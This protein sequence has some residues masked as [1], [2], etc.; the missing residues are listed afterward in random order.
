MTAE[1]RVLTIDA[2]RMTFGI[3]AVGVFQQE[4]AWKPSNRIFAA[5]PPLRRLSLSFWKARLKRLIALGTGLVIAL[6]FLAH[7]MRQPQQLFEEAERQVVIN[8]PETERLLRE[9]IVAAD[10]DFPK[11]QFLYCR[12]L[13]AQRRWDEALGAFG[14]ISDAS[15]IEPSELVEFAGQARAGG[16]DLLTLLALRAAKQPGPGLSDVLR[17]LIAIEIQAG[18]LEVALGNC[19]ELLDLEPEDGVAWRILGTILLEQKEPA[20]AANA[21]EKALLRLKVPDQLTLVRQHL[22]EALLDAGMT[23]NAREQLKVLRESHVLSDEMKL[24]EAYLD[25]LEGQ[26]DAAITTV[27]TLLDRT[28]SDEVKLRAHL[29][30]GLLWLDKGQPEKA[31]LSLELV[32]GVQPHNKEAHHKLAQAYRQT[33]QF[34][35]AQLHA[36]KAQKLTNQAVELLEKV[37][38]LRADP[39]DSEIRQRV[40]D[41]Y[42]MLGQPEQAIRIRRGL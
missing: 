2:G 34:Q 8:L 12:V 6:A 35:K 39:T 7:S 15:G 27:E 18:R 19:R 24:Q 38:R 21:F 9:A 10:G 40:S 5:R 30:R 14:G 1:R 23:E 32:V 36:G 42:E 26:A 20:A 3:I 31:V 33:N 11:A 13:A 16:A 17:K 29:L 4:I 41:L 25:R 37:E 28:S 22:V